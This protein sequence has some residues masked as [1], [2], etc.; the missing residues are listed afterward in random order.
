MLSPEGQRLPFKHYVGGPDAS[1]LNRWEPP[2]GFHSLSGRSMFPFQALCGRSRCLPFVPV[3]AFHNLPPSLWKG[4]V[5]L[6][7]IKRE[8]PLPPN[9]TCGSLPQPPILFCQLLFW[10]KVFVGASIRPSQ[11]LPLL[12]T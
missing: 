9:S 1:H 3:G 8:L 12:F 7:S 6:P 10:F 2:T 4:S 5:S 11:S